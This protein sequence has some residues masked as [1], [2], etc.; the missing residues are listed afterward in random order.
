MVTKITEITELEKRIHEMEKELD[1]YKDYDTLTNVYNKNA[2]YREVSIRIHQEPLSTYQILCID[3]EHFKLIND[4]YG[5]H[6]GDQLLMYLASNIKDDFKETASICGRIG[7]DIFAL[8][9][10]SHQGG[11]KAASMIVSV[12][13]AYQALDI[14][15]AF[16]IGIYDIE[17]KETS[18]SLMCDRAMMAAN[19]VKGLYMKHYAWYNDTMRNILIEEQEL[20]S[21][22]DHALAN[23]EFEVYLQPK[24]NMNSGKITGGEALVRWNHPQ[25]GMI[26]P[27]DFIPIFEKN[28]FIKKLDVYVWEQTAKWLHE[29]SKQHTVLP[30]SVN[31]SRID[32]IGL[33]VYQIFQDLIETYQLD[34]SW[35]QL[36]I[37]ESAYSSRSD[38]IIM[39]IN[40]LMKNGFTVL[41]D[42]FGSGYSSL[43]I[44]KDININVLKLDMRFL[45][46]HDKKSKDILE[47]VVQMAKWLDLQVIAEGVENREQVDFLLKI[48]CT[49]AQGFYY[50]KP[51]PIPAFEDLLRHDELID[52]HDTYLA[53]DPEKEIIKIRDLMHNDSV[54][55]SLLNNILGA[56]ALYSYDGSI[57]KLQKANAAYYRLHET[58]L[59]YEN[60][61][62]TVHPD[63]QHAFLSAICE[64]KDQKEEGV[65]VT[66]RSTRNNGVLNWLRIHLYFLSEKNGV[67]MI[68]ASLTDANDYMH[69]LEALRL[70]EQCFQIAME[71]SNITIFSVDIETRMASYAQHSMNDFG[72]SDMVMKAPEGFIEQGSVCEGYEDAFCAIYDDIYAGKDRASAI[73]RAHMG[74]NE[75]VWNRVTL[76]AIKDKF[77]HSVK[78]VGMVE[79]VTREI[80]LQK[81]LTEETKK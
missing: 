15:I 10:P 72:L 53:I 31:I 35:L 57:V 66:L 81:Q 29:W 55:E 17:D 64:T 20:L 76:I 3:I 58:V 47:S 44:L 43:N 19:T 25:K 23:G 22:V 46:K 42:D 28:G 11:E 6:Q 63:D 77:G 73:I 9:L 74:N 37:T 21:S 26:P 80:E 41:M 36:E 45:D 1:Y 14:K 8:L 27:K 34:S 7:P 2:F 49:H 50:Y 24:C 60:L 69:T 13:N 59:E 78:A 38:D 52:L 12:A 65:E 48:G 33:D 79:N 51:M 70:S 32:V 67:Q 56:V 54:S 75:L 68:Y 16:A 39:V 71:A 5:T 30:V 4:L 62:N 40:R 61:M 18:V